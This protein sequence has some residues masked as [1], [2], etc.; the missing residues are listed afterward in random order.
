MLSF[1]L[2]LKSAIKEAIPLN[3][4]SKVHIYIFFL[5]QS[6]FDKEPLLI[7]LYQMYQFNFLIGVQKTHPGLNQLN[8]NSKPGRNNIL[9]QT[10]Y[11]Y[12]I[13][14]FKKPPSFLII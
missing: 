4:S 8:I 1:L 9:T 11:F 10:S 12:F 14:G 3:I 5:L 7:A 13:K 6:I 2:K